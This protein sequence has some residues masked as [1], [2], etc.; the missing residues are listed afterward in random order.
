MIRLKNIQ[1]TLPTRDVAAAAEFYIDVLGFRRESQ[2]ARQ[3]I[4]ARGDFRLGLVV[5]EPGAT[6]HPQSA[7]LRLTL[8]DRDQLKELLDQVR[9]LNLTVLEEIH[10]HADGSLIFSFIAP[11]EHI[12]EI[13]TQPMPS[14]GQVVAES[15]PAQPSAQASASPP[16]T[17]PSS[18][19]ARPSR[20]ERYALESQ[21]LL[22]KIKE[23]VASLST[24]F[25]PA[26]LAATLDEM[27]QKVLQRMSEITEK[28]TIAVE[29]HDEQE[30]KKK[31]AQHILERY[32]QAMNQAAPPTAEPPAEAD[33]SKPVRKTLG[34]APDEKQ[35][36]E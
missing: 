16:A 13:M 25:S 7:Q 35:P 3:A 23:E 15:T 29:D 31:E 36:N 26:D 32:K 33:A 4:L 6:H 30:E 8:A 27:K 28:V 5:A 9:R 1:V 14:S 19:A 2:T 24:S 34:P 21:A 11:D 12:I 18:S 17:R 10:E 20:A 22:A